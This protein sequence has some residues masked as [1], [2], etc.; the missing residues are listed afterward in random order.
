[1][2]QSKTTQWTIVAIVAVVILGGVWWYSSQG[3]PATSPA[4]VQVTSPANQ[5]AAPT[6]QVKPSTGPSN[7]VSASNNSDVTLNQDLSTVDSQMNGL[8]SDEVNVGQSL[9]DQPIP[10][11]Q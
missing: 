10:Q 4:T 11:G 2:P 7:T 3:G 5:G 1:M 8:N 6:S 9:S